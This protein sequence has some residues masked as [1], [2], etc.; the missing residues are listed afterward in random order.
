MENL[1]ILSLNLGRPFIPIKD[2][3]KRKVITESIIKQDYDLAMLQGENISRNVDLN[4]LNKS[5]YNIS[6][7]NNTIT[8]YKSNIETFTSIHTT[9]IGNC[10]VLYHN[11]K[12]L[13]C[14]NINCKDYNDVKDIL[15]MCEFYTNPNSEGYVRRVIVTGSFQKDID[16]SELSDRLDLQDISPSL[17]QDLCQNNKM[18]NHFLISKNLEFK[19]TYKLVSLALK[20]KIEA[21]YP[22][23]ANITYKKVR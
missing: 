17:S 6:E 19:D 12:P 23:E 1:K 2:S 13:A 5:S 9:N 15:E 3:K 14:L 8:L 20:T 18:L 7:G 11:R 16:I 21:D 10:L 22:I 4:E